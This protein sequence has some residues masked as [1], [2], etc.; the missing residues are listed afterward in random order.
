VVSTPR[1]PRSALNVHR[2]VAASD[3]LGGCYAARMG[4]P[5]PW[6]RR[7][8]SGVVTVLLERGI[9]DLDNETRLSLQ[10]FNGWVYLVITVPLL[11][12]A[13][14]LGDWSAFG[15]GVFFVVCAVISASMGAYCLWDAKRQ[16][17]KDGG[18]PLR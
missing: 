15:R 14:Y 7:L 5:R 6:Y 13:I 12:Y 2:V 8:A 10:R 1:C 4:K 16:R 3:R 18:P 11:A 9:Y 17:R